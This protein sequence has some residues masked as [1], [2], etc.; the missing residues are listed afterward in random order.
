MAAEPAPAPKPAAPAAAA[1]TA[2]DVAADDDLEMAALQGTSDFTSDAPPL[3]PSDDPAAFAADGE[4]QTGDVT[5]EAETAPE[6]EDIESI[7]ARRERQQKRRS[8]NAWLR[9]G[10]TSLILMLV[11]VVFGL[12]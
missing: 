8:M 3:A 2:A 5:G 10:P 11:A 1:R 9:P 7:A 12:F 6:A 4:A